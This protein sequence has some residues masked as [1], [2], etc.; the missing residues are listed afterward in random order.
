[1]ADYESIAEGVISGD[2]NAVKELTQKAIKEG[3]DLERII[4]D[5]LVKGMDIVA[6]KWKSGE[7]FVPEVLIASRAM[8]SGMAMVSPLLEKEMEKAGIVVIGTVKG[9]VHNI[10]KD[11]VG[12]MLEGAGFKVIDLGTNVDKEVFTR[13]V[14][15]NKPSIVGISALLTTTMPYMKE[16]ISALDGAGLR[17]RLKIMI[18]GAPIN[19]NFADSIGADGYAEN[20][21]LAVEK[22]KEF[23][24][25]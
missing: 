20:A 17:E 13:A 10:G 15:E 25:A 4:Y 2:E 24:A 19:Q 3:G 16:V 11:L 9:D 8:K 6:A 7:F 12:L 5:G 18:G 14:Q 22:A 23:L 1:M 21:P